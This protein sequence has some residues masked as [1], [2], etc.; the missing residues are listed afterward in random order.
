[1]QYNDG[2]NQRNKKP[3]V[4]LILFVMDSIIGWLFLVSDV[5]SINVPN[6]ILPAKKVGER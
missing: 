1:M 6:F 3:E 5:I 4:F 2:R